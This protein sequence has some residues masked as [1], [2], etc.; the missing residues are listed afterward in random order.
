[1]SAT[2]SL[3]SEKYTYATFLFTSPSCFGKISRICQSLF[4]FFPP[5]RDT[6]HTKKFANFD[7]EFYVHS[8]VFWEQRM[9]VT[10]F[11]SVS[12]SLTM[13]PSALQS[14]I[15]RPTTHSRFFI[16]SK[17]NFLARN[18]FF[19]LSSMSRLAITPLDQR[20]LNRACISAHIFVGFV[21]G[22]WGR[23]PLEDPLF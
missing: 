4:L 6:R 3:F 16:S 13:H 8:T 15:F 11:A 18:F 17:N 9:N 21:F 10:N 1:M 7:L 22:R 5:L 23:T 19:K 2:C 14:Q 12:W 20:Q